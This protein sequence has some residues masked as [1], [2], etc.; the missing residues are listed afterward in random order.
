MSRVH[1]AHIRREPVAWLR[2]TACRESEP[3]EARAAGGSGGPCR[4]NR[5]AHSRDGGPRR[6]GGGPC[7]GP[8]C[9]ALGA[10][11]RGGGGAGCAGGLR[12][13]PGALLAD[14]GQRGADYGRLGAGCSAPARLSPVYLVGAPVHP[15]PGGRA[16]VAGEPDVG[17]ARR[18]CSRPGGFVCV[19]PAPAPGRGARGRAMG[20]SGGCGG[21]RAGAGVLGTLLGLLAGG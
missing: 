20:T 13:D 2:W 16:G 8:V 7:S 6:R 1:A 19:S 11:H 5:W 9:L 14:R 18:G 10:G 4:S 21:G 3:A 12:A 15:A 17:S